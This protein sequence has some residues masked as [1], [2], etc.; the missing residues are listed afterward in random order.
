MTEVMLFALTQLSKVTIK[1][2]KSLIKTQLLAV[3]TTKSAEV[4]Q[5]LRFLQHFSA[6]ILN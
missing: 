4:P 5:R 6:S 1:S 2:H 3:V